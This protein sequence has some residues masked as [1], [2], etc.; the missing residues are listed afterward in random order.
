M[1]LVAGIKLKNYIYLHIASYI[2]PT[3]NTHL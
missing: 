3:L 1:L 2:N